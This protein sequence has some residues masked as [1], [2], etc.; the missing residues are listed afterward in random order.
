MPLHLVAEAFLFFPRLLHE[1]LIFAFIEMKRN[2]SVISLFS[3]T[4]TV[5]LSL[6]SQNQVNAANGKIGGVSLVS[7][8]RKVDANWVLPVQQINANWVSIQPYAMGNAGSANLHYG[9]SHQWWGER[10]EGIQTL[11]R[12]AKQNGMQVM[13]KPMVWV[14]GSWAGGFDLD[15]E[16]KWQQWESNYHD[17][18]MRLSRIAHQEEVE[19]ICIGTELKIVSQK[20]AAFFRRLI[21]EL[22][23]SYCGQLTYAANWDEYET[24]QF[25]DDL[26]YI[27]VDAYFP[28]SPKTTPN[29]KELKMAWQTPLKQI[30]ALVAKHSKKVIFTEF[31]YRSIDGCAWQQWE[32]ENLP[33]DHAV[34][35]QAQ[36]NAYTAFF[37]TFWNKNWFAGVFLWQW[38]TNHSNAGGKKNSDF[39]P[40]NKPSS[41][42]ISEWFAH[43]NK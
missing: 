37:E 26:D 7:P 17:Y 33:H 31:G 32:T 2:F 3:I 38:Y 36:V 40:Q 29:V 20:R 41:D 39:T 30:G 4:F 19:M 9:S 8:S 10:E 25:W 35:L 27:G 5:I 13:L 15:S 21:A 28:L 18:I 24:I 43:E 6:F 34:N 23:D 16:E 1:W 42:L 12:H 22:R 11:I 14:H